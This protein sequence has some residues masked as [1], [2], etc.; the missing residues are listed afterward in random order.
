MKKIRSFPV[1]MSLFYQFSQTEA[2]Y[3][4]QLPL[5]CG[6][7][8]RLTGSCTR[9]RTAPAAVRGFPVTLPRVDPVLIHRVLSPLL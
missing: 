3:S 1:D 2:M 9:G 4:H 6:R 5:L 7:V 8:V